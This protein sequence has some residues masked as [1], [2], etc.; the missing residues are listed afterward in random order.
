MMKTLIDLY[1]IGMMRNYSD[2]IPSVEGLVLNLGAGNKL[3]KGSIPLD[4]PAWDANF[5]PIPYEDNSV[6]MIH[7]YHLLE[8]VQNIG[9]LMMEIQRVL[10]PG[11]HINIV[12]PY[13]TSHM[14]ASDIFHCNV[15]TERTFEKMFNY[16]YYE[17]DKIPSM[18]IHTN[19][20]M[21]DCEANLCL[22]TQLVK[23]QK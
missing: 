16:G 5:M 9:F 3:I 6:D 19:L 13:Y 8:H 2:I 10:K 14:Q 22:V 17:K 11:A 23:E 20:I 18:K 7:A 15:F 4:Y 1:N 21:A 12:V